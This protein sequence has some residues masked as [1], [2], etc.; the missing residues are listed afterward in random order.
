MMG[1]VTLCFREAGPRGLVI[2]RKV[3]HS[4]L[5][6]SANTSITSPNVSE[7]ERASRLIRL[8]LRS[9]PHGKRFSPVAARLP[10]DL[11]IRPMLPQG[12]EGTPKSN[13]PDLKTDVLCC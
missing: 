8:R 13:L 9:T 4:R 1:F 3:G 11:R 7:C 10:V 6:S 5:L 12:M 2:L